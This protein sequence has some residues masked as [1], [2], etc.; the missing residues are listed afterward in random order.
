MRPQSS[1]FDQ[2]NVRILLKRLTKLKDDLID[3][4]V[5][6]TGETGDIHETGQN[7]FV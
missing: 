7:F 3:S 5:L 1:T 6:N 2:V 4:A